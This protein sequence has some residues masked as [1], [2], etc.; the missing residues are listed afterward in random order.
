LVNT[1]YTLFINVGLFIQRFHRYFEPF[2]FNL[3]DVIERRIYEGTFYH[4]RNNR[5]TSACC[6][7]H[8]GEQKYME[9]LPLLA[10]MRSTPLIEAPTYCK[11]IANLW[12]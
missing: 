5:L 7:H 2:G 8:G 4:L 6:M 1:D 10:W 9:F 12:C 11:F 3:H